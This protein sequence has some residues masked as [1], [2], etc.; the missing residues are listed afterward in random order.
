MNRLEKIRLL[1]GISEGRLS[2]RVLMRP[3]TYL[4]TE[5]TGDEIYYE[6]ESMRLKKT[7]YDKF[8]KEIEIDNNCLTSLGLKELCCLIITIVFV[9]GK[10]IL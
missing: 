8:C 9:G 6:T 4:F 2:K 7:E 5:K 1:K 10:T 3:K